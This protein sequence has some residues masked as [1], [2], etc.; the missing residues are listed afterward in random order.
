M[1][2]NLESY[3][4]LPPAVQRIVRSLQF[5]GWAGFWAQIILGV[6][7]LLVLFF[8]NLVVKAETSPA[9]QAITN[10]GSG[11]G[12]AFALL[13]NL[14]LLGGGYWAF[15][16]IRLSRQLKASDSLNRPTPGHVVQAIKY[17]LYT[18]LAGMF[19]TLLGGEALVGS[20]F[21]KALSQPQGVALYERIS[22][23]VQPLDVLIV[24]ATIN[25]TLAHFIG[26]V[27]SLG[28]LRAMS[29]Q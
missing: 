27:V 24:Q 28:L 29:R 4:S 2:T 22:Q 11:I 26:L 17:G 6:V 13:G 12:L 1:S 7:S 18:N 21:A 14:M 16:Y 9:G 15:R 10:P 25:I 8:S 3:A 19:L 23:A 20:L 5:Y